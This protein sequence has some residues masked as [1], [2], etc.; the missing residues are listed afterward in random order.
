[1]WG[2]VDERQ[3][4]GP[5]VYSHPTGGCADGVGVSCRAASF[6]YSESAGVRISPSNIGSFEA[7][8]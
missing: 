6:Y 4:V 7:K 5:A 1:M 3:N 2:V 8:I